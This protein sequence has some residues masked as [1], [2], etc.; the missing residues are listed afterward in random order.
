M[1][2]MIYGLKA[3]NIKRHLQSKIKDWINTL[4]EDIQNQV[5][6]D[7]IIS[8]GA[9]ASLLLGEKVNDY[10]IYFKTKSTAKLIAEHYVKS[11]LEIEND[12][13][14]FEL[15]ENEL[16]TNKYT[17]FVRE[18]KIL[19]IKG[20][21]EDRVIIYIKSAGVVSADMPGYKYFEMYSPDQAIEF[22]KTLS[23]NA[24]IAG[25]KNSY[26]PIFLSDNAI[27]LSNKIQIIIRFF[28]EPDQIHSNYDFAH[29][30]CY[31]EYYTNNLFLPSEALEAMLSKTLYY[32]GSLYPLTSIFR[33]KKFIKRGWR[34]TAG[35][36]LK[37]MFQISEVNLKDPMILREQL[38]GVD[39]AYMRQLIHMMNEKKA[40]SDKID[41]NYIV[42][43]ID[44][45]FD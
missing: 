29:S 20:E 23:E 21:E 5:K 15:K 44:E 40:Q 11:Y 13:N 34:I 12:K 42:A 45:I 27:T 36:L 37:I 26:N 32:K 14:P 16:P 3:S 22:A 41:Y 10:D 39:V 7:T 31:Y 9:I 38:M 6:R 33:A 8:G 25:G 4:P 35:Q 28:G 2:N 17:P 24:K 1:Q 18:E 30:M 19:N 43:I